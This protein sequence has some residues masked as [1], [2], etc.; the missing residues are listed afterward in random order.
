MSRPTNAAYPGLPS[1]RRPVPP[2]LDDHPL[3]DLLILLQPRSGDPLPLQSPTLSR[4]MTPMFA[5]NIPLKVDP[6]STYRPM[7]VR[8]PRAN[9]DRLRVLS[10][11]LLYQ[12]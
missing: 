11:G 10:L 7:P 4:L 9:M 1:V 12:R 3:L 5:L 2:D 8:I 6:T